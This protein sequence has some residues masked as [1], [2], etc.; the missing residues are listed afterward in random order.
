[1]YCKLVTLVPPTCARYRV[2]LSIEEIKITFYLL[3]TCCGG[4]RQLIAL[5]D[6]VLVLLHFGSPQFSLCDTV[7]SWP[8]PT[9]RTSN[10]TFDFFNGLIH[11]GI[12]KSSTCVT[13]S[14]SNHP[15]PN[16]GT[17]TGSLLLTLS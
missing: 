15:L 11:H 1:M 12:I 14:L 10:G 16:I 7:H 9:D 2:P 4:N 6:V 17:A 3:Y 8:T 5:L 13:L